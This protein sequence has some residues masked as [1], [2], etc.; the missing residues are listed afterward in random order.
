MRNPAFYKDYTFVILDVDGVV[1]HFSKSARNCGTGEIS[2][3][4]IKW[5]PEMLDRLRELLSLP[6]VIGAWLTTWLES[7][8]MLDELETLLGLKGFVPLRANYP[9][10]EELGWGRGV[11][12]L[13]DSRFEGVALKSGNP[14]WWKYRAAEMLLDEYKP[15]RFVWLDDEL[16]RNTG[17]LDPWHTKPVT[18]ERLLLKTDPVAGLLPENF[19]TLD[20]W[21]KMEK[22]T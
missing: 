3:Y 13:K 18:Y 19:V 12:V 9:H 2:G 7:T 8:E 15:E 6:N 22:T 11:K 1:N 20:N 16:G 14:R 10:M 21:L 4:T 17:R 5:R